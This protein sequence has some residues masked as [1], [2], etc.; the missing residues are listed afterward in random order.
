MFRVLVVLLAF[1]VA[2]AVLACSPVRGYTPFTPGPVLRPDTNLLPPPRLSVEKVERGYGGSNDSCSDLGTIVLKVPLS[3]AGYAFEIVEGQFD[4]DT[5]FPDGFVQ[6]ATRGYLRFVWIDGAK[7][8]QEPIDVL[9]KI[10]AISAV[11]VLSEPLFLRIQ[12][13]GEVPVR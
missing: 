13:P 10:T 8:L 4:R 1:G 9:V 12:D 6:P 11:G 5:P 3:V 7:S 2:K